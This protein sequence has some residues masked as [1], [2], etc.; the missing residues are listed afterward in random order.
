[1]HSAVL[2]GATRHVVFNADGSGLVANENGW[3]D[4]LK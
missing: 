4:F 3:V 1:V 2:G